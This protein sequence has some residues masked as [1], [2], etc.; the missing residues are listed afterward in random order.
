MKHAILT[1]ESELLDRLKNDDKEAF[2]LLYNHYHHQLYIYILRFVK[3]PVYA[4][5]ILQDVFL[6][7]WEIRGRVNPELSFNSYLYKICKNRIFKA[8]KKIVNDHD[9]RSKLMYQLSLNVE[10]PDLKLL[11]NQYNGLLQ[12]AIETLP[13]QRKRV[14]ILCREHEKTYEEAANQLGISKNTVKEHMVSAMKS[15]KEYIYQHGDISLLLFFYISE[16]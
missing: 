11:W 16:K 9:M 5:D 14:Y 6:K 7:I 10:E 3:I 8:L 1:N 4:E 12:A 2:F 13:P 15:I